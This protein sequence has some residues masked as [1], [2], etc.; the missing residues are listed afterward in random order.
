MKSALQ[1]LQSSFETTEENIESY[2]NTM[3]LNMTLW[4]YYLDLA[5]LQAFAIHEVINPSTRMT[6]Q[7][8]KEICVRKW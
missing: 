6:V 4:S 3:K 2:I 1:D 8:F 5:A 7:D